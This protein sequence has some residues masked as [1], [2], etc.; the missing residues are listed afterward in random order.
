MV[1]LNVVI[2]FQDYVTNGSRLNRGS[3]NQLG[4][5]DYGHNQDSVSL[6]IF[7]SHFSTSTAKYNI[8]QLKN[9]FLSIV[10]FFHDFYIIN[11]GSG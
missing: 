5:N 10:F 3:E 4:R 8:F 2:F 6:L 11:S 7:I 9:C 1:D